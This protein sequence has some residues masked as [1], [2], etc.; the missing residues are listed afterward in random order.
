MVRVL[1]DAGVRSARPFNE[2][3]A[4]TIKDAARSRTLVQSDGPFPGRVWPDRIRKAA[5]VAWTGRLPRKPVT[6]S[7]ASL[8]PAASQVD[9]CV[10]VAED[11]SAF[12]T[13]AAARLAP[14]LAAAMDADSQERK[15]LESGMSAA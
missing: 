9:R 1:R 6:V 12:N 8:E 13:A 2:Y 11:D 15:A 4:E 14:K 5:G 10:V 3:L 7:V